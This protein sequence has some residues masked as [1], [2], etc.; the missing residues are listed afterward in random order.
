MLLEKVERQTDGGVFS[1]LY[2]M[3]QLQARLGVFSLRIE[4]IADCCR[5][6][7]APFKGVY[8]PKVVLLRKSHRKS[9]A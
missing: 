9:M 8:T 7:K 1:V 2:S 5:S 4:L 3:S 6:S